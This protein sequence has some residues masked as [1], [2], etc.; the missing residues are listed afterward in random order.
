MAASPLASHEEEAVVASQ[1][2]GGSF[3]SFVF[4]YLYLLER[5]A[6][7]DD[8]DALRLHATGV[9][10]A[11]LRWVLEAEAALNQRARCPSCDKP[12]VGAPATLRRQGLLV[13]P[14]TLAAYRI[15]ASSAYLA[16]VIVSE[17]EVAT[18]LEAHQLGELFDDP[19]MRS[20]LEGQT[21]EE[22][23]RDAIPTIYRHVGAGS[24]PD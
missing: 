2:A 21:A 14:A 22:R 19:A 16:E 1:S 10:S 11:A 3:V 7:E 9:S 13:H 18:P 5:I 12:A 24:A 15:A 6:S 20:F 17:R 4:G 23:Y 8:Q